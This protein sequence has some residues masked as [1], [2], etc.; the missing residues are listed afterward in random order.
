MDLGRV[1]RETW[2]HLMGETTKIAW[3][4]ASFNAWI[5]CEAI[6]P[7]C[8]HCYARAGSARLAAQHHLDLWGPDRYFT[9]DE[10]WKQPIKW[11][12]EAAAAG[13]RKL[14]F[15]NSWGDVFED[16]A[17]LLKTRARLRKL[18]ADTPHLTW[19][20]LTKRPEN[21]HELMRLAALHCWDNGCPDVDVWPNNV[22]LG[23][24]V[25][26]Q[27]RA[28]ERIPALV[29]VPAALRFLSCEPLLEPV[30]L[31]LRGIAWVIVG[32]ES[33]GGA[34]PFDFEWAACIQAQCRT[35]GVAYFMKQAGANPAGATLI[36][37]RHGADPSEWPAQLREQEFPC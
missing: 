14:V 8:D 3:T 34:R 31:D 10:Y 24:T 37:R 6:S 12:R 16:R 35:A 18:I 4:D 2:V 23:T 33:G 28:T 13:K 26:D 19:L 5:G 30:A 7:A 27:Q 15:C 25:E 36:D 29:A 11:N 22:W 21:A 17:D 1:V 32:G 20:L 9:K